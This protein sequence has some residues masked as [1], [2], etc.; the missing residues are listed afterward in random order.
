MI[1]DFRYPDGSHTPLSN[2]W[3]I[4][5]TTE[6][7]GLTYPST[8]NAYQAHKTMDFG[9]RVHFTACTAGQ[10]K[11]MGRQVYLR[12]DWEAAKIPL[13]RTLLRLKFEQDDMAR[14]L[15]A[16]GD[17]ILVEGNTWGDTFWGQC[18]VG[19]GSNWLGFL[20]MGIRAALK[21][22]GI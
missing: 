6:D 9:A 1:I 20:L 8:E 10:S 5:V 21:G 15:L 7:D 11:R 4:A 14:Y 12:E 19:E 17:H 13:M 3:P 16:T 2:F 18:P 22:A